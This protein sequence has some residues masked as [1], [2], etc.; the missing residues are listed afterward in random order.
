MGVKERK[1][2]EKKIRGEQILRAA[3]KVFL[4][5]GFENATVND[6]AAQAELGKGTLYL[7]FT[8]KDDIILALSTIAID[9]LRQQFEKA[10]SKKK[11]GADQLREA[12]KAYVE[13]CKKN[14]LKYRLINFYRVQPLHEKSHIVT[15]HIMHCHLKASILM[16]LLHTTILKGIEDGSVSK[17]INPF[18]TSFMLWGVT[19]GVYQLMDTL[20]EHLEADHGLKQDVFLEYYFDFMESALKNFGKK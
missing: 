8:N 9:E 17:K 18:I 3:E 14:P 15:P 6:V 5:K 12:G 2:K 16:N 4:Q 13:Y 1:E 11:K 19:T 20:G 10:I 7:H